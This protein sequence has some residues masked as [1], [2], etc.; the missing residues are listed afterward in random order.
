VDV[1][2]YEEEKIALLGNH[3]SQEEAMRLAM[4]RGF[5]DLCRTADAYWGSL[6]GCAYAECF[7]P[8]RARGAIKP[9]NVLP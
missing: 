6:A 2:D 8:M 1:S 5:E 3:R 7:T 4:G 9:F